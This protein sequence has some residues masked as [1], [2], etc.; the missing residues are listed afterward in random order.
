[1]V[2]RLRGGRV[3]PRRR[4]PT[5]RDAEASLQRMVD[6]I[7]SGRLEGLLPFDRSGEPVLFD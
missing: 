3:R 5:S 2:D 4:P 1:M 6:A 7:K